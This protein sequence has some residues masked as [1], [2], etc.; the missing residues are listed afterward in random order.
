MTQI[1]K[2]LFI[3]RYAVAMKNLTV[4]L[5]LTVIFLGPAFGAVSRLAL[6]PE[7]TLSLKGDSTLHPYTSTATVVQVEG[8]FTPAGTLAQA[9]AS[10]Q[11]MKFE[12]TI[13]VK[14]LKSG[15]SGLDKR[16]YKALNSDRFPDI[17]FSL[18]K[19]AVVPSPSA[20]KADGV[21]SIAGKEKP[22]E[23][24]AALSFS[25]NRME[26][27]GNYKLLMTDYGIKP[28]TLMLGAIKV[29]APVTIYFDLFLTTKEE[30]Q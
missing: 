10:G 21:L 29:G 23:L 4:A 17:H 3:S 19:Y 13:P 28:P 15:E 18:S 8:E 16:L 22:V 7:S 1:I 6:L 24:N 25:G 12:V 5:V 11:M 30:V 9:V 20:I 26:I 27:Q 14:G 2:D